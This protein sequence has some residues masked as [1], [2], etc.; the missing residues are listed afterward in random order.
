MVKANKLC[1]GE[2]CPSRVQCIHYLQ[3]IT[4]FVAG[5]LHS[6]AAPSMAHCTDGKLFERDPENVHPQHRH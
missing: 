6:D 3:Y 1:R 5:A 2:H 4:S